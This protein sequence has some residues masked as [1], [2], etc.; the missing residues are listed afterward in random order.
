VIRLI[1]ALI[2]GTVLIFLLKVAVS[3]LEPA[4]VFYP[5]RGEDHTPASL[6][7][8]YTALKLRTADGVQ[9]AAWQLEPEAPKADIVY[10]HG[11]G[12][13]LSLWLPVLAAFHS[14]GYRVLAVDYRGYGSSEGS[15]S[16]R[17][18]ILDAEAAVRHATGVRKTDRPL[19]YW[20]R[21]LGGPVAAAAARVIAPDALVLESTFPD[22][23]SV[24]RWN[25]VFRALNLFSSYRFDTVGTLRGFQKP[26]LV[27]HGDADTIIPYGLGKELFERLDAPKQ[28]VT[29][30]GADHNDLFDARNEAYWTPLCAFID[31][32]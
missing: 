1:I 29:L 8:R 16:E 28:L 20:G 5:L 24:I 26:V 18:L 11:N 25:P 15:P 12:G 22:K 30:R 13:N 10:F 14:F 6:G 4:M 2:I 7:I 19:I 27:V 31:A 17:G 9:I 32:L 3:R 21:S 23:V